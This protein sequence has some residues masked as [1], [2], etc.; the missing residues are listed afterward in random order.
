MTGRVIDDADARRVIDDSKGTIDY[1]RSAI[2]NSTSVI[3]DSRVMPKLV[4]SFM[5]FMSDA[6]TINVL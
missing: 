6:C 1:F 2:D 5:I 3:D 4:E